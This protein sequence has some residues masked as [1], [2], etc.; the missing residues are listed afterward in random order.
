[1]RL[2]LSLRAKVLLMALGV[3]FAPSAVVWSIGWYESW[4]IRRQ[5][6]NNL[7]AV[8]RALRD[9][10]RQRG[11]SLS[12][13]PDHRGWLSGFAK[14][15]GLTITVVDHSGRPLSSAT[16]GATPHSQL[17]AHDA[18]LP[19]TSLRP[20]V[21]RALA[22]QTGE[23]WRHSQDHRL[24]VFYRAVPLAGG[25]AL[26]CIRVSWRH[27]RALYDLR[28][29]LLE[30]TV[31]LAAGVAIMALWIGLRLVRPI[32]R[33]QHRIRAHLENPVEVPP[34]AID[35]QR[36]DEIGVL[37]R[38]VGSLAGSLLAQQRRAVS[39][40]ADLAHDL[41]NPIATVAAGAELL[42]SQSKEQGDRQ[43][44]LAAA[45][46]GAAEHMNR[47]VDG[48]LRLARLD[49]EL[50]TQ[51][52][53]AVDLSQLASSVVAG[54]R[55][56]PRTSHLRWTVAIDRSLQ[57]VGIGD[58]LET[59][60][61]NLLENA[62]LFARQTVA[63]SLR[64]EASTENALRARLGVEDDGPGISA[65]NLDKL[66]RRFFTSRP[67][68]PPPGTGLGLAIS[69]AIAVAHHGELTAEAHGDLGGARFVVTVPAR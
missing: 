36:R 7:D 42:Q 1:L 21:V 68:N 4:V 26:Y 18:S 27:V 56:D 47:S 17:L 57:V 2:Q 8:V 29:P 46:A 14:K 20:E 54:F 9:Q 13:L 10:L 35:L 24:W 53:C 44:R 39:L 5:I 40:A 59:L 28:Y 12:T 64:A 33:V 16:L 63:V 23:A 51:R 61:R 41:K 50:A 6:G 48:L 34:D 30:L 58:Q 45:L 25:G 22:G 38:D 55:D 62:I 3:V 49:H 66:F 67:E 11:L 31:I 52:R 69:R 65:G 15:H 19:P 43:A 37:S 32:T 60:L